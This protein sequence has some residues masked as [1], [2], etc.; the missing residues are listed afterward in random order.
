[1]AVGRGVMKTYDLI[2][3]GAGS[4]N[5]LLGAEL[6]HLRTAIVDPGRF[7]GTCLN[8]GCIPSKM[9]VVAADAARAVG[10]AQRL[11]V[12]ATLDR[13]DWPAIRCRVFGRIDPLHGSAVEHRR[14]GG[15]LAGS[16]V[17]HGGRGSSLCC[18]VSG[19]CRRPRYR[20]SACFDAGCPEPSGCLFEHRRRG[21]S[22]LDDDARSRGLRAVHGG[23]P[24]DRNAACLRCGDVP[25]LVYIRGQEKQQVQSGC[26]ALDLGIGDLA[27]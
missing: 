23:R 13:V 22:V 15:I 17:V 10:D 6:D 3:L 12:H 8:H 11:G 20:R 26:V 19:P 18:R 25:F 21:S 14:K 1:M 2:V 7:G 4:G 24:Q 5:M 9:L 16:E 27:T